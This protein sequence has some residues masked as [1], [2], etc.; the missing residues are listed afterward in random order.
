MFEAVVDSNTLQGEVS[1]SA[2]WAPF[3]P[4]YR[5]SLVTEYTMAK[6][7]ELVHQY[8]CQLQNL[9]FDRYVL[10]S[11][12]G[13]GVAAGYHSSRYHRSELLVSN[14][15]VFGIKS[16]A[17][18]VV[19]ARL[20]VFRNTVSNIKGVILVTSLGLAMGS[21]PGPYEVEEWQPIRQPGSVSGLWPMSRFI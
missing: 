15:S 6:L 20:A 9:Q 11:L 16:I 8:Y 17:N 7:S 14:N 13:F 18:D 2:Q 12:A 19:L 10:E 5:V 4:S 21:Q 3:N 1:L